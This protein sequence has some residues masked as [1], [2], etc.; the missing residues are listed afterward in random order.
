MP[1]KNTSSVLEIRGCREPRA[2]LNSPAAPKKD[3]AGS[4][5]MYL[6]LYTKPLGSF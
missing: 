6:F 5:K 4:L 1:V 2:S 3:S